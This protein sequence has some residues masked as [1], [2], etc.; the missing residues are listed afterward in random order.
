MENGTSFSYSQA[1]AT[2]SHINPVHTHPVYFRSI[3]IFSH[4]RTISQPSYQST[5][6]HYQNSIHLAPQVE[7]VVVVAAAAVVMVSSISSS[8]SSGG[9][10]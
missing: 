3:L 5:S 7:L 9:G 2:L 6:F 8:S 1:I 4:F 10:E